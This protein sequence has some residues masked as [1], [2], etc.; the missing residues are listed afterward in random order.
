MGNTTV[1]LVF[2]MFLNILMWFSQV[3][4]LE[5]NPAGPVFLNSNGTILESFSDGS[6]LESDPANAL[7]SA[8]NVEV[9]T[10]NPFTDIFNNILGW[11]TGLP[12]IN[13]LTAIVTAPANIL[14]SIGLP[15][16]ICVGLG[17]LWYGISLFLVVAFLW[18]RE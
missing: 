6:V 8:Q 5:I 1:A 11:I 15:N 2:V 13:Y 9:S 17:V 14:K 3:A 18:G 16:Q 10:G 7:P 12:G 4:A